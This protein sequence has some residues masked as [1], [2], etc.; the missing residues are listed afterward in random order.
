[1]I[2]DDGPLSNPSQPLFRFFFFLGGLAGHALV[3]LLV[4]RVPLGA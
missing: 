3:A 2:G 1:M 4:L